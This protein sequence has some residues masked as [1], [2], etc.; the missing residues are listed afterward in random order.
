M[1]DLWGASF[2]DTSSIF[3]EFK[4]KL[5]FYNWIYCKSIGSTQPNVLVLWTSQV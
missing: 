1:L 3:C 5:G 4:S 2:S